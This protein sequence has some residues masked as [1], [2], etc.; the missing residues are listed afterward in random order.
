LDGPES[1]EPAAQNTYSI[2][3]GSRP[4]VAPLK[5]FPGPGRT[6]LSTTCWTLVKRMVSQEAAVRRALADVI[7][8]ELGHR[9]SLDGREWGSTSTSRVVSRHWTAKEGSSAG[10]RSRSAGAD[11]FQASPPPARY[12]EGCRRP[13]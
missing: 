6:C 2:V 7:A 4:G 12:D 8:T 11:P 10:S 13:A 3:T 1:S 5:M 9:P